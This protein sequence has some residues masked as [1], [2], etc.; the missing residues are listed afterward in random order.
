[1]RRRPVPIVP[2]AEPAIPI[3]LKSGPRSR[4]AG[5][6]NVGDQRDL[7]DDDREQDRRQDLADEDR[8]QDVEQDLAD[9]DGTGTVQRIRDQMSPFDAAA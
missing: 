9:E 6:F 5:Q 8:E 1:M 7:A 4:G 3:G 2:G